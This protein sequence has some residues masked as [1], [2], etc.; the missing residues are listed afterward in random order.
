ML[1]EPTIRAIGTILLLILIALDFILSHDEK[2]GNTPREWL[3]MVS[4]RRNGTFVP[5]ALGVLLGHFYHP[6]DADGL[7]KL[8]GIVNFGIAAVIGALLLLI[9]RHGN[10]SMSRHALGLAFFGMLV[11]ILIWPV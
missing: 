7:L 4:Q 3:L 9:C 10:F 2:P 6:S 11:G 8:P 5:Y 1:A